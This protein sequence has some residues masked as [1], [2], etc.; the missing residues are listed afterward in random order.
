MH[1]R[2]R[3]LRH[4]GK[5]SASD[6]QSEGARAQSILGAAAKVSIAIALSAGCTCELVSRITPR[7]EESDATF[8]PPSLSLSRSLSRSLSLALSLSVRGWLPL[9]PAHTCDCTRLLHCYTYNC[10]SNRA[11]NTPL[12]CARIF[13]RSERQSDLVEGC[14]L[15]YYV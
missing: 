8:G 14:A 11:L 1:W 6:S 7:G 3:R 12:Q 9:P 15:L 2:R 13:L 10:G 5:R 4:S